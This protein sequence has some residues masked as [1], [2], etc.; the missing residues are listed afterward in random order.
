MFST[1]LGVLSSPLS[2]SLS[3]PPPLFCSP[4]NYLHPSS[5]HSSLVVISYS[6]K[7]NASSGFRLFRVWRTVS[8][9]LFNVHVKEK[10]L[11]SIAVF[12]LLIVVLSWDLNPLHL[13]SVLLSLLWALTAFYWRWIRFFHLFTRQTNKF[14]FSV[15]SWIIRVCLKKVNF[16]SQC[17]SLII[18]DQLSSDDDGVGELSALSVM[19][20]KRTL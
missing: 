2:T 7:W 6:S 17:I 14:F 3:F 16:T 9:C 20:T 4:V 11:I 8:S 15:F 5:S 13:L 12:S 10:Y 1:S 18:A 19:A